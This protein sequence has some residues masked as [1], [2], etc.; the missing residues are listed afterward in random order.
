MVL[1]KD[2]S[3][4]LKGLLETWLYKSRGNLQQFSWF[5][6]F[7][8]SN[9][10]LFWKA[11]PEVPGSTGFLDAGFFGR[12]VQLACIPPLS[13]AWPIETEKERGEKTQRLLSSTVLDFFYGPRSRLTPGHSEQITAEKKHPSVKPASFGPTIPTERRVFPL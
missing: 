12:P 6:L 4:G 2:N 10:L 8:L 11:S 7:L 3:F 5:C 13:K 9:A 1:E